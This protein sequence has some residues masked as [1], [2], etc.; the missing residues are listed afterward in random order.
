MGLL[1]TTWR[2]YSSKIKIAV[3]VIILLLLVG[4]FFYIKMLR[5]DVARVED[6]NEQLTLELDQSE[7]EKMLLL[8]E[9]SET[10]QKITNLDSLVQQHSKDA[11]RSKRSLEN[12]KAEYSKLL[13]SD[14]NAASKVVI[15]E[16]N[17]FVNRLSCITGGSECEQ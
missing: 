6:K 11:I 9:V 12:L 13:D 4:G 7:A 16:Y 1:S 2:S 5:S 3:F 10:T 14:P 15:E 17:G 8:K